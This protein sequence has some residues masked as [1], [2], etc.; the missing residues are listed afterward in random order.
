MLSDLP[1]LGASPLEVGS[2]DSS[3][4]SESHQFPGASPEVGCKQFPRQALRR[5]L[6]QEGWPW[7]SPAG[8]MPCPGWTA[9]LP[10]ERLRRA[11]RWNVFPL[12]DCKCQAARPGS[13]LRTHPSGWRPGRPER[14]SPLT[15]WLLLKQLEP[16][17]RPWVPAPAHAAGSPGDMGAPPA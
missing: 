10:Y 12:N 2:Q 16:T 3:L 4:S 1:N 14:A 9:W 6:L 8:F 15:S 17:R 11:P 13:F 5:K 7:D